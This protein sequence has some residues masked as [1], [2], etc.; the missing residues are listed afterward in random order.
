MLALTTSSKPNLKH[1][2]YK[3]TV[4]LV[5]FSFGLHSPVEASLRS[6]FVN[7]YSTDVGQVVNL[8]IALLK[9]DVPA[10]FASWVQL[11]FRTAARVRD[12]IILGIHHA[13]STSKTTLNDSKGCIRLAGL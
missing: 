6:S 5:A 8:D 3:L 9:V 10:S 12:L 11:C 7:S 2:S 1:G 13:C 4:V